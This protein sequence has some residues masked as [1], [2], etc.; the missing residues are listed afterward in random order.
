MHL[1][2]IEKVKLYIKE[3][4]LNEKNNQE[5]L[6][7]YANSVLKSQIS[8]QDLIS[9]IESIRLEKIDETSDDLLLELLDFLAG[10]CSPHMKL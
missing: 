2:E 4:L 7:N 9:V 5:S 1:S 3:I 6:I 8:Q 10:W